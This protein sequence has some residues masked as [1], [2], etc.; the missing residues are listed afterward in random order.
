MDKNDL[1]KHL[2]NT[3]TLESESI[4]RA[5]KKI[6]RA[7][8]VVESNKSLA[9]YDEALLIGQGQTISQPLTVVFMLELLNPQEDQMVMDIGSGSAWQ[10]AL[11]AE[12]VGDGGAVQAIE[13]IP[14]VC[15]FGKSNIE[16]YPNIKSRI[17]FH[18]KNAKDGLPNIADKTN[19]F[20]RIICAAEVREVPQP[21]REQLKNQG[22]MV[23][24]KDKGIYKETKKE[25]NC[26]E[27][28]FYPGFVFVPF[29]NN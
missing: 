20:D 18:C 2:K 15:E 25:E 27:K 16:K 10:S 14:K 12:I 6:D 26:F 11:L 23:Y 28:E 22:V 21:W 8:F 19:G 13:I 7:D 1:I 29:V 3:G 17:T 24:P 5:L 4:V 9:Y